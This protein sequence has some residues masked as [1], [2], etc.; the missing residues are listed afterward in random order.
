MSESSYPSFASPMAKLFSVP[1]ESSG[2]ALPDVP[3][4]RGVSGELLGAGGGLASKTP[5][6][7]VSGLWYCVGVR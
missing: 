6:R 2:T 5:R 7:I 4:S 3:G 1:S